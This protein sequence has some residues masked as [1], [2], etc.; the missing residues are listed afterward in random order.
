MGEILVL[1]LEFGLIGAV[2]IALGTP[3]KRGKIPPNIWYGF[4]TRKTLSN[5]ETW[6]AV[7]RVTGRD[8]IRTGIALVATSLIVLI[9]RNWLSYE[10]ALL[11]LL[12]VMI[13][14]VIWMLVNGLSILKKM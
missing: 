6:Y 9:L 5:G 14:T 4:R 1:A 11:I 13:L 8:M 2:F 12:A 3:L 7:N 10:A